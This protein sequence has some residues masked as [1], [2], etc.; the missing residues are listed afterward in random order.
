MNDS[1]Q[2]NFKIILQK[3]TLGLLTFIAW[4]TTANWT[5][6]RFFFDSPSAV[7]NA[8]EGL[9]GIGL[10]FTFGAGGLVGALISI[11][12]FSYLLSRRDLKGA[13]LSGVVSI[14]ITAVLGFLIL[15]HIIA[16]LTPF[17]G[18]PYVDYGR[19]ESFLPVLPSLLFIITLNLFPILL[20]FSFLLKKWLLT[21][22][23][24][25]LILA[26]TGYFVI[27]YH[28]FDVEAQKK[29]SE[30][31]K[32][33]IDANAL[34]FKIYKPNYLPQDLQITSE[35]IRSLDNFYSLELSQFGT[36]PNSIKQQPKNSEMSYRYSSSSLSEGK[37]IMINGIPG[38]IVHV[39]CSNP[40]E[41]LC[42][43]ILE[44][45]LMDTR[46]GIELNY[47]EADRN[48]LSE[49]ELI[50]IAV[51]MEPVYTEN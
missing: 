45:V 31:T 30:L 11:T 43:Q 12:L 5:Y 20:G 25:I 13:L 14:L 24:F 39:N 50:K 7:Q 1:T 6:L 26:S 19:Y 3:V 16:L 35:E 38:K 34:N 47:Y 17:V 10:L 2:L 29:S 27:S 22:V 36:V 4:G 37:T 48:P 49:E 15:Y 18:K 23:S 51:S 44:W 21:I 41:Q 40:P 42:S 28:T 8:T 9:A 33:N 32:A 46:I